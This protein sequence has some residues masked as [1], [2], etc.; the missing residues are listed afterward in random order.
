MRLNDSVSDKESA[1][2]VSKFDNLISRFY[3][4]IPFVI[5]SSLPLAE[6]LVDGDLE[7][8]LSN[9]FILLAAI[10]CLVTWSLD[11]HSDAMKYMPLMI[12]GISS[13][14][15]ITILVSAT[16]EAHVHAA[17]AL[18][19]IMLWL[20]SAPSL[21]FWMTSTVS[22]FIL[23]AA[24]YLLIAAN[25]TT[26]SLFTVIALLS[27]GLLMG[28]F[29]VAYRYKFQSE[30]AEAKRLTGADTFQTLTYDAADENA[31][32]EEHESELEQDWPK[33]LEDLN[34]K[35]STIHDVDV[36]FNKMLVFLQDVI[37]YKSA[38]IGMM[39]ERECKMTQ[40]YG[41]EEM[42]IPEILNWDN[43]FVR[44]LADNRIFTL[45]EQIYEDIAGK[46]IIN[47]LDLPILSN[48]KFVGVVT[49][50]REQ[51]PFD[52][53]DCKLAS[54]IVF[55]SMV[56]L[57]NA[58][59]YEE[60]RRLSSKGKQKA[61]FTREQF[62]DVSKKQLHK[63][64]QPRTAS[65]MVAEIDNY[66]AITERYGKEVALKVYSSI[67][68]VMLATTRES[69]T[70]GRYGNE[71]YIILLNDTDM[72][73]A[74]KL[75]ERVREVVSKTPS[76]TQVGKITTTVS[77]GLSTASDVD[78]DIASLTQRADMALFVAKESGK[79]TVKVKL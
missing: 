15:L 62:M 12:A 52:G 60:F 36:L 31:F 5:L 72:L 63:L 16:P 44:N 46:R 24:T 34:K 22:T 9:L 73:D 11:I 55:H 54:S 19:I 3:Y 71:G 38:A 30:L 28:L 56:A 43:Q 48:D 65:L 47:R 68:E 59:L 57:R 42:L 8:S 45:R 50:I 75:A 4:L 53:Y 67:S 18:M 39:Q 40:T 79:N 69:D 37:P 77:I 13:T 66:S 6:L 26:Q 61:L 35:L 74:K 21:H 33:V 10:M 32:E 51:D 70:L 1:P 41:E 78:E 29:A 27:S 76:K 64:S 7:L 23:I 20:M 14:A 2:K 17:A 49:I 25:L 58:R